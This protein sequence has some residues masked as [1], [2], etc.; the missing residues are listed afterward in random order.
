MIFGKDKPRS[1]R[2]LFFVTVCLSG[3]L[4]IMGCSHSGANDKPADSANAPAGAS[5]D[6]S[7]DGAA[8][9]PALFVRFIG[10]DGGQAEIQPAVLSLHGEG[11]CLIAAGIE[12]PADGTEHEVEV[13]SQDDIFI[14]VTSSPVFQD[15][16]YYHASSKDDPTLNCWIDRAPEG[17]KLSEEVPTPNGIEVS[18]QSRKTCVTIDL[19][20]Q[21]KATLSV[22]ALSEMIDRNFP[23]S[24]AAVEDFQ[25][26]SEQSLSEQDELD[27][28]VVETLERNKLKVAAYTTLRERLSSMADG[29]MT[30]LAKCYRDISSVDWATTAEEVPVF[31]K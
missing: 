7:A 24:E 21:K 4:L 26:I 10:A 12:V 29:D 1:H 19:S 22:A 17:W 2:M 27:E 5:T 16:T 25:R 11:G 3:C 28:Y 31:D 18:S 14:R 23:N 20:K 6:A 9:E 8:D 15:G 13:D 30:A